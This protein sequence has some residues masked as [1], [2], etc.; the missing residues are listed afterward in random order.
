G[1]RN[2]FAQHPILRATR[3]LRSGCCEK[4]RPWKAVLTQPRSRRIHCSNCTVAQ[5]SWIAQSNFVVLDQLFVVVGSEQRIH[6]VR[7]GKLDD[8]QPAVAECIFV[9]GFRF[10]GE[11]FI[12]F[13]DF[14][15]D[16]RIHIRRRLHRLDHRATRTGFDLVADLGQFDVDQVTQQ[17]LGMI[18]NADTCTPVF[19]D[20]HPFVR[21]LEF[22]VTGNLAHDT[23]PW[24]FGRP[25][26][27]AM[28]TG[29]E[30]DA[31]ANRGDRAANQMPSQA[32]PSLTKGY[33]TARS[34]SSRPRMSTRRL[35][36]APAGTRAKAMALPSVGEKMPD[37]ISPSPLPVTTRWPWRSTPLSSSTTPISSRGTPDTFCFSSAARPMKSRPSSSDTV[38]A[39][40]ASHGVTSSSM[41]WPYRFI[42]ASSRSVSRAPKPAGCTPAA[43]S[44]FHNA[45]A[46]SS[47]TMIS[48][49]SSPV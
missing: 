23:C 44:A 20:P 15:T 47:G 35:S 12:H 34:G 33:F 21:L 27:L 31:S 14:A 9:D 24:L 45:T 32:W 11:P 10:V 46:C 49:P 26:I 7:I 5:R 39:R 18:G 8:E 16:R 28:S 43:A 6:F 1:A 30:K 4:V 37:R 3:R 38:Q 17:A 22:E 2:F 36:R 25:V 19:L 41:S 42:P 40:P 48:K 13:H 29:P